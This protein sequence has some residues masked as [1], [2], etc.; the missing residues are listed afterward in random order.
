L[1]PLHSQ[2]RLCLNTACIQIDLGIYNEET[3]NQEFSKH[4]VRRKSQS[5]TLI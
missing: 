3:R 5:K 2:T 4:K 1:Y